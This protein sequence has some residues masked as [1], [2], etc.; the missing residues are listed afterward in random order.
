MQARSLLFVL[1]VLWNCVPKVHVV[2]AVQAR[3]LVVVFAVEYQKH[4]DK[5]YFVVDK[6]GLHY[7]KDPKDVIF[8]GKG[9]VLTDSAAGT[10][11]LEEMNILPADLK[12]KDFEVEILDRQLVLSV[13]AAD[14]RALFDELDKDGSGN[15]D[16]GVIWN[17]S[18]VGEKRAKRLV[19]GNFIAAEHLQ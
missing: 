2:S 6:R 14:A 5:R 3:S 17:S 4:K 9:E 12:G 1:A 16:Q 19:A 18:F 10:W 11:K 15:L 8:D 13:E 7:Y